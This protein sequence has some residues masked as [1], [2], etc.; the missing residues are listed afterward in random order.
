MKKSDASIVFTC[1][2]CHSSFEF[3][4]VGENEFVPC[5]ICGTDHMTIKK[6]KKLILETFD[7]AQMCEAQQ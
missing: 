1:A 6:G 2:G 3:D 7:L 5:P 4:D